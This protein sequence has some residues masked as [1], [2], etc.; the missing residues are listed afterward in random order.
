MET[1]LLYNYKKGDTDLGARIDGLNLKL[2][3]GQDETLNDR[4][5]AAIDTAMDTE[6][7]LREAADNQLSGRLNA[8]Q[9]EIDGAISTY[10]LPG[11]P[12][13]EN[14]P[15]YL[16]DEEE[17]ADQHLGDLY[18]DTDT[19][20]CYR[21]MK[22]GGEYSWSIV[23]D[24]DVTAALANAAAAQATADDKSKVYTGSSAPTMAST[25]AS[26]WEAA[27]Y[28]KHDGD[29]YVDTTT[30][31]S[32]RFDSQTPGW[33]R[34]KDSDI[35]AAQAAADSKTQLFTGAV[36]PSMEN[37]PA[38]AWQSSDY[39]L[40]NGDIY[41]DTLT[42]YTYRFD[43]ATPGWAR[44][45]DSDITAAASAAD[46]CVLKNQGISSA[47]RHLVV[48]ADGQVTA[49]LPTQLLLGN[50]TGTKTFVITIGD[51]GAINVSEVVDTL[52]G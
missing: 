27:D 15:A 40:H 23:K 8:M 11:V 42:G 25:P 17:I 19:G 29:L 7:A 18:Y 21:W 16:W 36:A 4:I 33:V 30:G 20:Y 2:A 35:T 39:A 26:T 1:R 6:V 47:G 24:T 31:Y 34:V 50:A 45:K 49:D 3:F 32:Y 14:E 52:G 44:I 12:T 9:L 48:G 5:T 37:A 51:D 43:S 22:S 38:S 46:A 28:G 13:D 10:F 41:V